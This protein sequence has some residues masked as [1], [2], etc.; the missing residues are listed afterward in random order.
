MQA[1]AA[2]GPNGHD[3]YLQADY[4]NQI[5]PRGH[6]SQSK[7]PNRL[8][9]SRIMHRDFGTRIWTSEGEFMTDALAIVAAADEA[10]ASAKAVAANRPAAVPAI[11]RP[12]SNA[13]AAGAA[14]FRD[15]RQ[16]PYD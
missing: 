12:I 13:I 1:L 6:R 8:K 5:N 7:I 15:K 2:D 16:A 9:V 3:R 10:I 11:A 14:A 4:L